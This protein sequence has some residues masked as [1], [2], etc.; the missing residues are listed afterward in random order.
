MVADE[1]DA[2]RGQEGVR[3]QRARRFCVD[4][5]LHEATQDGRQIRIHGEGVLEIA[6]ALQIRTQVI[7]VHATYAHPGQVLPW[8]GRGVVLA[9]EVPV[10]LQAP[11]SRQHDL[12]RAPGVVLDEARDVIHAIAKSGPHAVRHVS[13]L[14]HLLARVH[15]EMRRDP[16][17]V[18][19]GCL[20]GV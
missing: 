16:G 14:G 9:V 15:G 10:V 19:R 17:C 13:V 3:E 7:R 12:V 2:I 4:R 11:P 1:E 8:S 18:L 20:L 6:M 5:L